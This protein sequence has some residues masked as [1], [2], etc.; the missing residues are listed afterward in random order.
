[1]CANYLGFQHPKSVFVYEYYFTIGESYIAPNISLSETHPRLGF[2]LCIIRNV[3]PV[4][5]FG[6]IF[7]A[8]IRMVSHLPT[9]QHFQ[10]LYPGSIRISRDYILVPLLPSSVSARTSMCAHFL[11]SS[12]A[13]R[14][15]AKE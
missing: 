2:F 6:G 13:S 3:I 10:R 15:N 1:M 12:P 8:I 9:W 14:D 11:S 7:A 5:S 4:V